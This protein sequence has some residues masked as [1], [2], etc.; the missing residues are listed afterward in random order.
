[1]NIS[2]FYYLKSILIQKII[3]IKYEYNF[4]TVI[5][6]VIEKIQFFSLINS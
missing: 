3:I 4:K 5:T 6:S 1:M 2:L